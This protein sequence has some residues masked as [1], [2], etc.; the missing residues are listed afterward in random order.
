MAFKLLPSLHSQGLHVTNTVCIKKSYFYQFFSNWN[1]FIQINA[2]PLVRTEIK[3][4]EL[5]TAIQTKLPILSF[6]LEIQCRNKPIKG[7][8]YE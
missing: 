4:K 2:V 3:A 6:I 1:P 5:C 7:F 8:L